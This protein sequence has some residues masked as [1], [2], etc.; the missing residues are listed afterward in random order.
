MVCGTG[1]IMKPLFIP[2]ENSFPSAAHT[3]GVT[4]RIGL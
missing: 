4:A 3:E 2:N 1:A